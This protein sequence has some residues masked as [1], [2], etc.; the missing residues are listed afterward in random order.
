LR[1]GFVVFHV[2]YAPNRRMYLFAALAAGS[3]S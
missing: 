2:I 3:S 1:F